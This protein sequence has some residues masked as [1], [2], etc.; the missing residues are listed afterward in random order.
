MSKFC[1][2]IASLSSLSRISLVAIIPRFAAVVPRF[3]R[4]HPVFSRR[5]RSLLAA[6]HFP[7]HNWSSTRTPPFSILTPGQLP[8]ET[9]TSP[10]DGLKYGLGCSRLSSHVMILVVHKSRV[11][12][13]MS[14]QRAV[15]SSAC[16]PDWVRVLTYFF[17]SR[18]PEN[19]D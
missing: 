10:V 4:H 8:R 14:I 5:H 2:T 16:V 1:F 15:S 13:G 12:S 6:G 3:H 18:V 17:A 11:S 9:S 7:P 19:M